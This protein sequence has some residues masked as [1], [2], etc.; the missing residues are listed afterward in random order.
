[1]KTTVDRRGGIVRL[2]NENGKVKVEELSNQFDVSSVTIRNDLDYLEKKGIVHRTYGG[3]LVRDIVAYDSSLT[4]KQNLHAEEKRKIGAKAAELIHNGD[5]IIL[6][7]GTTTRHIAV[8]IKEKTDLTVLTNA[9]NIAVELAGQE[10]ITVML[11]GG[12]LRKKSY[13]LVGPEA[14]NTLKNYYFDRLFL[15]VD[16]FDLEAGLTTPNP[17]EAQLNR[18]MVQMANEVIA[19]TDSSKFGRRSFSFICELDNIDTIVTDSNI[20]KDYKNGL[21]K[22]NIEVII[23]WGVL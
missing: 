17:L 12:T 2:L 22:R 11:T 14:E 13:S 1:M 15:G 4:E 3:A 16:G 6:D 21:N 10:K 8:N 18:L 20:P 7:S 9:I 19:V 5:S 23:V